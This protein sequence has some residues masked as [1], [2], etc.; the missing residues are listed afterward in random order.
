MGISSTCTGVHA[1]E[2]DHAI[3]LPQRKMINEKLR[4]VFKRLCIE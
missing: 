2:Y 4:H 1:L 3:E